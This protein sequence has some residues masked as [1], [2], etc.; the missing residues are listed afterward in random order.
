MAPAHAFAPHPAIRADDEALGRDELQGPP[1]MA[2]HLLGAPDLQ[3]MMVDDADR[4]LLAGDALADGFEIDA[5]G[6]AGFEG[7]HVGFAVEVF[8]R[9][10]VALHLAEHALLRRVAPAAVAPDLGLVAQSF[11]GV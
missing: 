10:L 2:G 3:R 8:D 9:R 7:D 5:A 11:D 4:D 1:D 6:A